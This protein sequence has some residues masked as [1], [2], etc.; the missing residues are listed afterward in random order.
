ML[1]MGFIDIV[2]E[3]SLKPYDIIPLIP[4]IEGAGGKVT[5]WEGG[6]PVGGGR[7]LAVGDPALHDAAMAMLAAK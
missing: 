1:A 5:T 2:A 7:I 4:V 3:A 6:D